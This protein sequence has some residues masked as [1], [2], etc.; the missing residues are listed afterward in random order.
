MSQMR[1]YRWWHERSMFISD[2]TFV[3]FALIKLFID[4][5]VGIANQANHNKANAANRIQFKK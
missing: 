2:E 1:V 5:Q 4:R 3:P